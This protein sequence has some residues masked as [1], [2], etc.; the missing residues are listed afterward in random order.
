MKRLLWIGDAGVPS[1]FARATH[2][3]LNALKEHY[4]VFVLGMNYRGDPHDYPY[5]IWAASPGGDSFG[6][7]R[8]IWMCDLVH[9]D[10]IIIQN[11]PWNVPI[12]MRQLRRFHEYN[13]IPVVA[14]MPVD[15]KNCN[16]EMLNSVDLAVFWTQF[17]LDEAR[18]GGFTRPAVIIP[19]GV[20]TSTF[21]PMDR[22]EVRRRLLPDVADDAFIIGNVN[23]N[24]PRKRWDLTV[25]YFA[26]WTK[27]RKITNAYLYL[28]TAPTGDM[29][30]DVVAL[31][32]YYGATEQLMLVE[33]ATWYGLPDSAM[34]D[35][36]NLF[37]VQIS[38][39]QGEGFGLTTFEGM[40][41]GTPQIVPDWSAL[42]EL[43][44][45]AA[46]LIPCT[47]TAIGPPYVNVI[48]GVADQRLFMQALDA[49]YRSK[50]YREV[51][52]KAALERATES[53]Y[54]WKFIGERWIEA[55]APIGKRE[56]VA[57]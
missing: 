35:T 19:L 44:K 57:A 14:V 4:E 24:Q 43:C 53:C 33:P 47:S 7:G 1:G 50:N 36:Y 42:G 23:R 16:G 34:R 29:G 38:T 21:Y 41:C 6:V 12:Y 9:P 40:A 11:D 2:E 25:K 32:K 22:S 49:L 27:S 45:G 55:L 54:D 17:G 39:T 52:S 30:V 20:D 13:H 31:M 15:G 3:V 46:W 56:V 28:H 48:G 10:L 5:K 51:N 26:E 8:M 18:D 37:D